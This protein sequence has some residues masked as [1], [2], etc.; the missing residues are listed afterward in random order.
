MYN[1]CN[2]RV[3]DFRPDLRITYQNVIN[4]YCKSYSG[5]DQPAS[6]CAEYVCGRGLAEFQEQELKSDE[7]VLLPLPGRTH[8][9]E[10]A[11][12]RD[13]VVVEV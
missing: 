6:K 3:P 10:R 2:G 12:R 1:Q 8:T 4:G 9:G 13:I 5:H 11:L 7:R